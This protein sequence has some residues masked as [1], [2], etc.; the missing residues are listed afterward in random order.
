ME[1]FQMKSFIKRGVIIL[2]VTLQKINSCRLRQVLVFILTVKTMALNG[3]CF[4]MIEA[5]SSHQLC[6]GRNSNPQTSDIPCFLF[7]SFWMLVSTTVV[8]HFTWRSALEIL[9]QSVA[10]LSTRRYVTGARRQA[11]KVS[12]AVTTAASQSWLVN[13]LTSS[14]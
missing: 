11:L 3:F 1:A 12:W 8:G 4:C 7:S 6:F 13:Q 5:D 14:F 9:L 10:P 2:V